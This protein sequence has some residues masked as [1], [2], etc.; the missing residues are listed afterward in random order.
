M[1]SCQIQCVWV[2]SPCV[3]QRNEYIF[4]LMEPKKVEKREESDKGDILER[5]NRVKSKEE[6]GRVILGLR[7]SRKRLHFLF[8]GHGGVV[9]H[10]AFRGSRLADNQWHTL[11]LVVSSHHVR[12]TVDCRPPQEMYVFF[13]HFSVFCL[14]PTILSHHLP[15]ASEFPW[16]I[17]D[18]SPQY[19]G[20]APNVLTPCSHITVAW[21]YVIDGF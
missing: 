16:G 5:N 18:P 2:F 1:Y 14:S 12:L 10:W 13:L 7:F 21:Q 9:E 19:N 8:R 4:S 3:F 17:V 20:T 15:V 11:V 6:R